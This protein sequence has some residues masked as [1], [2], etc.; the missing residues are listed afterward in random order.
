MTENRRKTHRKLNLL[1]KLKRSTPYLIAA[2]IGGVLSQ[3]INLVAGAGTLYDRF[4][5]EPE[6]FVLAENTA[7]SAFS[8]QLAQRALRRIFW[9]NNFIA[10][11]ENHAPSA[12]VDA[13]WRAY[14]DADADWNANIM[15]SIVGLERFYG[16]KR[17]SNLEGP[18]QDDFKSLDDRLAQLRRLSTGNAAPTDNQSSVTDPPDADALAQQ[19]KQVAGARWRWCLNQRFTV[20][21]QAKCLNRHLNSELYILVRCFSRYDPTK[22]NICEED[23]SEARPS[24]LSRLTAGAFVLSEGEVRTA[25]LVVAWLLAV[26]GRRS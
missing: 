10:R 1:V 15:I 20:A 8:D 26:S 16:T 3:F 14:I 11:V 2:L 4:F 17:S 25:Q 22:K 21:Q 6:A 18:I 23:R 13:S 7:K 24:V 9:A 19:P 5:K 12:D